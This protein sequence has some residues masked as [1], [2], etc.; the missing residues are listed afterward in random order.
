MWTNLVQ[1]KRHGIS[2]ATG[3]TPFVVVVGSKHFLPAPE[4]LFLKVVVTDEG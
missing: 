4:C 2:G 3:F 1:I